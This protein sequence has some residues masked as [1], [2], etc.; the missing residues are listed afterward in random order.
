MIVF[1]VCLLQYFLVNIE[2]DRCLCAPFSSP[3]EL[4]FAQGKV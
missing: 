4:N 1:V 3:V 2:I